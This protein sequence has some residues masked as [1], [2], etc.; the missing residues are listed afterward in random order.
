[1]EVYPHL[2]TNGHMHWVYDD[3]SGLPEEPMLVIPSLPLL[4]E[5]A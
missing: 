5:A 1:M 2:P 3:P 4:T